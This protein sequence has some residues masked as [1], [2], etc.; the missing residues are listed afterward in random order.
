[1]SDK[2]NAVI[3]TFYKSFKD[4]GLSESV[5]ILV[6][7]DNESRIELTEIW[8]EKNSGNGY[9]S[10]ALKLLISICYANNVSIVLKVLPLRYTPSKFMDRSCE[11]T[12]KNKKFLDKK[13]LQNWYKRYGFKMIDN[14][15]SIM[16][17]ES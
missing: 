12:D 10:S 14:N 2:I 6:C 1:M 3:S 16:L 9:A 5:D 11:F 17:K 8:S 15:N 13:S 7:E 4:E